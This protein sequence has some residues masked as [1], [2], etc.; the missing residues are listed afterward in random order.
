MGEAVAR[1]SL[2]QL[3]GQCR[4]ALRSTGF[5]VRDG[6]HSEAHVD[7]EH[8]HDRDREQSPDQSRPVS[9]RTARARPPALRQGDGA[10]AHGERPEH[11]VSH[12]ERHQAEHCAPKAPLSYSE[13]GPGQRR[14]YCRAGTDAEERRRVQVVEPV[15]PALVRL[16]LRLLDALRVALH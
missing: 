1:Q 11:Q 13:T 9:Q 2:L 4:M 12:E 10:Q 15:C 8:D 3:L 7:P 6:V 5:T 16:L 14:R